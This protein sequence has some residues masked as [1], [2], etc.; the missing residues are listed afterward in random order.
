VNVNPYAPP[1]AAV[2]DIAP[3]EDVSTEPPFFAV[4][5]T[6]L[7]IMSA[8][9]F[10]LYEMYWFYRH[11]RRIAD[12]ERD[13]IWPVARAIFTLFFCYACFARIR[14]YPADTRTESTLAAGP[15]AIGWIV[16]K[17]LSRLPDPYGWIAM[18]AFVFLVPVQLHVN[19]LNAAASPSHDRNA[20]FSA[21]NWLAVVVGGLL[22]SL[23]LASLFLP[24]VE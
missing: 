8:C 22:V 3:P 13:D 20:R 7:A 1:A 14:D 19:E 12:R 10:N 2:A 6:K 24:D 18:F 15:L 9:T 17:L 21:W 23:A 11:W 5:V 16:T 4:S